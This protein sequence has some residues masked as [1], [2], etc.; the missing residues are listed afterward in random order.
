MSIE[1][2]EYACPWPVDDT[3]LTTEWT[4]L[5]TD[6]KALALAYASASLERLT[7]YR[8]GVCP[9]KLRPALQ[10]ASGACWGGTLDPFSRFGPVNWNGSWSNAAVGYRRNE[11][12]LPPPVGRIDEVRADGNVIDPA[13]YVLQNG[14]ILVWRG[15]GPAPWPMRQDTSLADTEPGT[16]SVTYLNAAAVNEQGAHAV[17][18]LALQFAKACTGKAC[19]LPAN[20]TQLVRSGVSMNI[21]SG[22]F[23]GGETGLRQVDAYTAIYNPRRQTQRATVYSPDLPDDRVEVV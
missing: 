13:D 7:A 18:L 14:H 4:D 10:G 17:T 16:M 21:A 6:V 8:V 12:V 3:C 22:A 19:Q 23:P 15:S 11:V 9:L 1:A 5:D 2:V 20:V